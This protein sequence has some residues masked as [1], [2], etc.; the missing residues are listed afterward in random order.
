MAK[1]LIKKM[2]K[3]LRNV[4]AELIMTEH[5][6][7]LHEDHTLSEITH[8]ML[9]DRISGIPVVDRRGHIKGVLSLSMIFKKLME[10]SDAR[11]GKLAPSLVEY[12]HLPISKVMSRDMVAVKK[13]T[14]LLEMIGILHERDVNTIL[15]MRGRK[16]VGVIGKHDIL[17]AV[18]AL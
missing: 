2:A 3:S 8:L 6:I 15:V 7:T 18:F 17:N 13:G 12:K 9:R 5:V 16:L 11:D 14:T 10:L 4:T 1:D